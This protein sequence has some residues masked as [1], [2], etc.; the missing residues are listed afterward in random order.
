[1]VENYWIATGESQAGWIADLGPPDDPERLLTWLEAVLAAGEA[2]AVHRVRAGAPPAERIRRRWQEEGVLDVGHFA[3]PEGVADGA[4]LPAAARLAWADRSGVVVEGE[5]DD[6]G[7]LLR[8]LRPDGVARF[9][10]SMLDCPP[11][12]LRGTLVDVRH[13]ERSR[14]P[15]QQGRVIV[16]VVTR[17][18][19][20]SPWVPGLLA[21]DLA[22]GWQDNRPLAERHTP[23]LNAFLA[24][25]R[26][27][28][29][30]AGGT[31]WADD[32][33]PL[34]KAGLTSP[35]GVL[36]EAPNPVP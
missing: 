23:R 18:D 24:A 2:H 14:W 21:S 11:L 15:Y 9:P 22:G 28:T 12:E 1:V 35:A 16:G 36:L 25:A 31:W 7:V 3:A 20:W 17:T 27:A 34:A 32:D 29:D 33:T 4:T 5:V 26:A 30:A 8:S 10:R 13:P 6:A 19:I